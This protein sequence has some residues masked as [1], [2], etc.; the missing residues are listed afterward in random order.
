[1]VW[2][3][4]AVPTQ[5]CC[6]IAATFD[7][8]RSLVQVTSRPGPRMTTGA[9]VYRCVETRGVLGSVSGSQQLGVCSQS[10]T[11]TRTAT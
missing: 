1:M 8:A 9:C 11:V 4:R 6:P 7:A 2:A 10:G 5:L 3:A